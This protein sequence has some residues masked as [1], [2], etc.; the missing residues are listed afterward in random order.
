M[1][2]KL[3]TSFSEAISKLSEAL[4]AQS[5]RIDKLEKAKE[6]PEKKPE[7]SK[8]KAQEIVENLMK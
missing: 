2:E 4:Q 8:E 3:M 7:P 5:A 1:D 6:E